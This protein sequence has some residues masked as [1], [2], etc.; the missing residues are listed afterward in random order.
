MAQLPWA[1]NTSP[2]T[3]CC[4]DDSCRD[5]YPCCIRNIG[6]QAD[7]FVAEIAGG[8]LTGA[9]VKRMTIENLCNSQISA[10]WSTFNDITN[11][12]GQVQA[13]F[14]SGRNMQGC[15][16][17]LD[18]PLEDVFCPCDPAFP[19]APNF[20]VKITVCNDNLPGSNN[21]NVE[22]RQPSFS[23]GFEF[24]TEPECP[25]PLLTANTETSPDLAPGGTYEFV[26]DF[27]PIT[28][29]CKEQCVT[30][31]YTCVPPSPCAGII[32]NDPIYLND[33]YSTTCLR[34]LE[35][36]KDLP[37]GLPG[38][39]TGISG[40]S[41]LTCPPC[42]CVLD[43]P[44]GACTCSCGGQRA[45][46]ACEAP[47]S[48]I[49][50]ASELFGA[51]TLCVDVDNAMTPPSKGRPIVECRDANCRLI[52]RLIYP[53][54]EPGFETFSWGY[55]RLADLPIV[56]GSAQIN[57]SLPDNAPAIP[58]SCK[59]ISISWN[60]PDEGPVFMEVNG[61]P[62]DPG[63]TVSELGTPNGGT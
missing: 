50:G 56:G 41:D 40:C 31:N 34:P 18:I 63:N 26:I 33:G 57:I 35:C 2:C 3:N 21:I 61:I 45:M 46:N 4:G 15:L 37:S 44:S 39:F 7:F 14:P 58:K 42:G 20:R 11:T 54:A 9:V 8:P 47:K 27:G 1:K 23:L 17:G 51:L 53:S 22:L 29:G 16:F 62:Q 48:L 19:N 38:G 12:I 49:S 59:S 25:F 30:P 10:D 60:A 24:P 52:A 43:I 36:S 28:G 55:A 6:V 13:N 32:T 5:H